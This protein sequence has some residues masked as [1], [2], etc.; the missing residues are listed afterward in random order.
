M[1][2]IAVD[3]ASFRKPSSW[4]RIYLIRSAFMDQLTVVMHEEIKNEINPF[5]VQL[6][7]PLQF[8]AA[9]GKLAPKINADG[10]IGRVGT[11]HGGG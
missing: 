4:R 7:G 3:H 8:Q 1:H 5:G 10:D 11:I 9:V 2:L 6:E